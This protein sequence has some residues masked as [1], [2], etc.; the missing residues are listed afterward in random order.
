MGIMDKIVEIQKLHNWLV[1][2]DRF[3]IEMDFI[4]VLFP[5]DP[6]NAR[7]YFKLN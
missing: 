2:P 7:E 3:P 1:S 4:N 6:V 5:K